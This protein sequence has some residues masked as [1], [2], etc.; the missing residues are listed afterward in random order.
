MQSCFTKRINCRVLAS[1]T[2]LEAANI[3]CKI[4]HLTYYAQEMQSAHIYTHTCVSACVRVCIMRE[5]DAALRFPFK[6]LQFPQQILI[7]QNILTSF[8]NRHFT[9]FFV[10]R[11][12]FCIFSLIFCGV[13]GNKMISVRK[14]DSLIV[15]SMLSFITF[16]LRYI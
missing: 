2:F 7:S 11:C 9:S 14:L 15:Y 13:S 8:P 3:C 6:A 16:F 4:L 5:V 10:F 12:I 1:F